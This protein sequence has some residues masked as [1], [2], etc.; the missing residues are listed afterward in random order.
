[1]IAPRIGVAW[2]VLGNGQTAIR[3]GFGQFYQRERVSR[4]QLVANAPFAVNASNIVR[5]LG[6]ATPTSLGGASASPDGGYIL[7]DTRPS[8]Y[9]WNLTV[10]QSLAPNTVLQLSYVGNRGIHLTSSYDA[11]QILPANWLA[12]SFDGSNTNSYRPY[13]NFGQLQY[14]THQGDSHYNALQ[15]LFRT[16]VR[17]FRFQAAY[18]WSHATANVL[19][20]NSDGGSG[21]GDF[22]NYLNPHLDYGNSATNRPNIFVA[23]VT[24]FTPKLQGHNYLER[25]LLGNWEVTGITNADSGNS[26]TVYQGGVGENSANVIP[27]FAGAGKLNALFQ[28]G[29]VNPQRPLIAQGQT[30]TSSGVNGDQIINPNAFTL[31][32]YQI[33]TIPSNTEPR[34]YC[35]GPKLINT[36]L[37][38]DKNWLVKERV[39]VKLRFS[40]FDLFNHANFRADQGDF[41][42]ANS[43]NCG[44][45][46]P[47]NQ[48]GVTTNMYAPCSP[49]NNIISH[50]DQQANFGKSTGLVGNAERQFLYSLHIDF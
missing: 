24:Y 46:A 21:G 6:G 14:W 50:F 25:G 22:T 26:F 17:Q 43:A 1:M 2:D 3:A 37:S 23:N 12:A 45:T 13:S 38:L 8:S 28:T 39:N 49:T 31:V 35:H 20:D 4:Y 9:Q 18:T 36:D 42:L 15:S 7:S 29:L 41:T 10:E 32:G 30:C 27:S 48:N 33:G 47:V 19:T 11:N 5:P 34:G 16:Q 40:A 44:A